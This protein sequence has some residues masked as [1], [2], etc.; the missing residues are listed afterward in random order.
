M[1]GST[2]LII[3]TLA[4][5]LIPFSLLRRR[6]GPAKYPE[7]VQSLLYDINWNQALAET[8]QLRDKPHRFENSNW[9]MNKNRLGFLGESLKQALQETFALVEEFN[10]QMKEAKKAKSDS[11][12]TI[13]LARFK[14]L[15][16]RCRQ[17]LEDW[18][19][20]KTGQK[21]LPP[22]YPTLMGSLFGER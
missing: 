2:G 8:C 1:T 15:L 4:I 16:A 7:I 6:G 20:A 11:Y 17:E 14:E 10:R 13:D 19:V 18:M 12:K 9:L 3:I 5:I 21:E 22:K